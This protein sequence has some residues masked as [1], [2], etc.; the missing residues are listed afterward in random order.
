MDLTQIFIL[1][2]VLFIAG[3]LILGRAAWLN[4]QGEPAVEGDEHGHDTMAVKS[5]PGS[6]VLLIVVSIAAAFF[7]KGLTMLSGA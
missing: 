4:N 6:I 7:V 5:V 2:A 1:A 3:L